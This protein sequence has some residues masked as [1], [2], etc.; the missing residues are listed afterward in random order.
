MLSYADFIAHERTTAKRPNADIHA[1]WA[2]RIEPR[3]LHQLGE[4]GAQA[5]LRDYG[6]GI[7]VAKVVAFALLA[8]EKSLFGFAGGFWAKAYALAGGTAGAGP[9][10]AAP[11]TTPVAPAPEPAAA[12]PVGDYSALPTTLQPG[13]VITMQPVDATRSR[14][15]FI[16]DPSYI[17]Q[18]KRD[19]SR[20]VVFATPDAVAYQARSN[21]IHHSPGDPLDAAFRA[22]ATACGPFVV[23]GELVYL[24]DQGKEHRTGSQAAEANAQA[25]CPSARV[26][27]RVA[28]FKA[29]YANGQDLTSG[30]EEAR[31]HAAAPIAST[32]LRHLCD[33]AILDYDIEAVPTAWT[34]E[35]KQAL[36]DRQQREGR[37][38]EVWVR[39]STAYLPG[40]VP[41]EIIVRT[42][43][44]MESEVII[45]QLT[46][47]TVAGRP[48]GA[49]DVAEAKLDGAGRGL[50]RV[51]TGF[52]AA[53][54]RA[55]ASLVASNPQGVR[56]IV[57][58]QGYTESGA[59]WHARF[60]RL[61]GPV[62]KAA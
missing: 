51:G 11:T 37:E 59:L 39:R 62:G 22:A 58:H 18:P 16:S 21:A 20:I 24:D 31:I 34:R 6:K 43:Y 50:G 53:D 10:P 29:L 56:I 46:P 52:D 9:I 17:G 54:A 40:K 47:T 38:G 2:S 60:L 4:S 3:K 28:L 25:G 49:I 5:Y 27:C 30:D 35:E 23:D 1:R 48:F 12:V 15:D 44:L 7:S 61:V 14:A 19:G 45:V 57:R 55:I 42:K 32:G 36:V 26:V 41:G 33:A 8:E 13:A